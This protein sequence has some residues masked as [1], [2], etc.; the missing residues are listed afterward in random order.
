MYAIGS[1]AVLADG[2][3]E[4]RD[5][6]RRACRSWRSACACEPRQPQIVRVLRE[7]APCAI[8]TAAPYFFAAMLRL[9]QVT[10]DRGIVRREPA[11]FLERGDR[12]VVLSELLIREAEMRQQHADVEA[13][14][15][16]LPR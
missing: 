13:P 9:D 2:V 12:L 10:G 11:R 3:L 14:S 7:R 8:S 1:S 4:Q 5:R 16:R 15:A 6:L